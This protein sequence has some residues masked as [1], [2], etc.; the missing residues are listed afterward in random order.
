MDPEHPEEYGEENIEDEDNER[1]D[2]DYLPN[3]EV[4]TVQN[5]PRD[6]VA[7]TAGAI[8]GES[9]VSGFPRRS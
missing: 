9:A 4:K 8:V 6:E 2:G 5:D 1:Q 7:G 3:E